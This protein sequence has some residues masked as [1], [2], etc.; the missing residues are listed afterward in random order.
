MSPGENR[1]V[2]ALAVRPMTVA[3]LEANAYV[4]QHRVRF[5]LRRLTGAG[6]VRMGS[7]APRAHAPGSAPNYWEIVA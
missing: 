3:E 6:V 5:L 7:S 2:K 1:I 4:T